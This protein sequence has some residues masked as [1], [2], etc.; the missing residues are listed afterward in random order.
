MMKYLLSFMIL[1]GA[2]VYLPLSTFAQDANSP[3]LQQA[4][5]AHGGY[6]TFQQYHQVEYDLKDWPFSQNAPLNDHQMA[7]LDNRHMYIKADDYEVG[8]NGEEAWTSDAE[9]LGL[10]ADFYYATPF[11]FFSLPFVF[12]D[13]GANVESL[14][15]QEFEGKTYDA[16]RVTYGQGVGDS[17]DDNYVAYFN[18]DDH[19][20]KLV[21]YVVTH[22]AVTQGQSADELPRSAIVYE[23]LQEANGLQVPQTASFYAWKDG[24]LGEKAGTIRYEN[25][26]FSE[27]VPAAAMFEESGDR[28]N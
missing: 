6:E 4:L 5:E 19:T 22:S 9:A 14:E 15:P 21:H 18:Q 27:D 13:P 24:R 1:V 26:R 25:V 16:I 20:L 2:G 10:P 12:A 28:Q 23:T 8:Y 11:Y 7:N 17:P 3:T